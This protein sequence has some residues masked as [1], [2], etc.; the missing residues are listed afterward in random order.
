MPVA[1]SLPSIV[2]LIAPPNWLLPRRAA[3]HLA[4]MD[5]GG[6]ALEVEGERRLAGID[7]AREIERAAIERALE[8]RDGEHAVLQGRREVGI[9]DAQR[10]ADQGRR[11]QLERCRRCCAAA[12]VSIA[13]GGAAG[14][15]RAGG[16]GAG[17][18]LPPILSRSSTLA[19]RSAVMCG[20][21]VNVASTEPSMRL[22]VQ[23]QACPCSRRLGRALRGAGQGQRAG[24]AQALARRRSRRAREAP[25]ARRLPAD[26][27]A[28][29]HRA[30]PGRRVAPASFSTRSMS[31]ASKLK[32]MSGRGCGAL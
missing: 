32:A 16:R 12:A 21:P 6:V 14:W 1:F 15:P 10:R 19:L 28:R 13:L 4:E 2:T 27:A 22:A 17:A 8:V 5:A 11:H 20:R 25:A 9:A 26:A 7:H 3:Q 31:G 29:R 18:A 23:R 24:R 30:Q